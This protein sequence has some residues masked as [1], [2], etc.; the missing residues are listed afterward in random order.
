MKAVIQW[1]HSAD[2]AI[3]EDFWISKKHA[4]ASQSTQPP[5]SIYS[6]SGHTRVTSSRSYAL[7]YHMIPGF[8]G[9]DTSGILG[10]RMG[11]HLHCYLNALFIPASHHVCWYEEPGNL[12]WPLPPPET[13]GQSREDRSDQFQR[14]NKSR[15]AG[16]PPESAFFLSNRNWQDPGR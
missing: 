15:K 12:A 7:G 8:H 2:K 1:E 9:V 14:G 16:P 13:P 4:S 11:I 3:S 5:K 6:L 10:H